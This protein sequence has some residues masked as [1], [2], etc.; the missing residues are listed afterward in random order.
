MCI[1]NIYS[2]SVMCLTLY[3]RK[4]NIFSFPESGLLIYFM[5]FVLFNQSFTVLRS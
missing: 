2:Q 4:T 1:A 5:F 3:R